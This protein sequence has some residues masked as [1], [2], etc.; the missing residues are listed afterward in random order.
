MKK[1][2][3]VVISFIALA[4]ALTGVIVYGLHY[5]ANNSASTTSSATSK[6]APT[7]NDGKS[8]S[9]L[10]KVKL[11]QLSAEVAANESEVTMHTSDGDITIKFF[12]DYAPLAVYNFMALAKEGYFNGVSFHRI[13]KGFMIQSGDPKGDGTG[14][15]SIW[16]ETE[17]NA[18]IDSGTGFKTET[19][20]SLYNIRGAVAMANTGSEN[21][22]GS[23]FFINQNADNQQ[24]S[25]KKSAYPTAIY[26]AY[27]NGGNPSLDGKYTVFGQVV[28]GMDIVDKIA[29]TPVT[30]SSTGEASTPTEQVTINSIDIVKEAPVD[31]STYTN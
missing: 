18:K 4:A 3:P 19:S 31:I 26:K 9:Q 22:N 15:N 29:D 6:I 13:M 5:S 16:Y 24:A 8:T 30:T 27:K 21:S 28:A 25:L 23:Q 12:N 11:P 14:G 7:Q 10:N 17:K 1:I 2:L 20:S